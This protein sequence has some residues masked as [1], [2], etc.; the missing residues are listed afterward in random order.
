MRVNKGFVLNRIKGKHDYAERVIKHLELQ[1]DSFETGEEL[2]T[3]IE[4]KYGDNII[5]PP[6]EFIDFK[7]SNYTNDGWVGLIC[8]MTEDGTIVASN[9]GPAI[10]LMTGEKAL[11]I[12]GEYELN[13]P[14]AEFDW[15]TEY[16]YKQVNKRFD[17]NNAVSELDEEQEWTPTDGRYVVAIPLIASYVFMHMIKGG[18]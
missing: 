18:A 13:I 3:V 16:P 12:D 4:M 11:M 6:G 7:L 15:G 2:T 9:E 14:T 10:Y 5:C 17:I 8:E 1:I